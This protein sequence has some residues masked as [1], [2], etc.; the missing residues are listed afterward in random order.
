[1]VENKI[2]QYQNKK[3]CYL[4]EAKP[5]LALTERPASICCE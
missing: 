3:D 2:P 5:S 4:F 1:M